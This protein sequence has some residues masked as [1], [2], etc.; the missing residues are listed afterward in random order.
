MVKVFLIL[1]CCVFLASCYTNVEGCTDPQA[2]NYG[3]TADI[4]CDDCC[5]YPKFKLIINHKWGKD[6]F[7]NGKEY[8]NAVG[9]RFLISEHKLFLGAIQMRDSVGKPIENR[10]LKEFLIKNQ[11]LSLAVNY[12]LINNTLLDCD[13]GRIRYLG[14]ISGLDLQ[15]GTEDSFDSLDSLTASTDGSLSRN[16]RMYSS[17]K[18]ASFYMRSQVV[19]QTNISQLFLFDDVSIKL[20]LTNVLI[21][22]QGKDAEVNITLDYQKLFANINFTLDTDAQKRQ[23]LIQAFPSSISQ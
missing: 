1:S 22:Q 7:Q 17:S 9:S 5:V 4:P 20:P 21:N 13:A 18:Y 19:G 3:F 8:I 12:C 16:E 10:S 15:V 2:E 14:K 11:T 23:K 6:F